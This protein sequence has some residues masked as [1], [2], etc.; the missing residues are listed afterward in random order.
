MLNELADPI[1][2]DLRLEMQHVE[3][4]CQ[5]GRGGRFQPMVVLD[6]ELT[7][8]AAFPLIIQALQHDHQTLDAR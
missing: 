6:K 7:F 1:S 8:Y 4:N 3:T 2:S 5:D